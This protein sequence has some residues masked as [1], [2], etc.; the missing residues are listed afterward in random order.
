MTERRKDV[1]GG[2]VQA[3]SCY[4]R[5]FRLLASPAATR[6]KHLLPL[7]PGVFS[8]CRVR[9]AEVSGTREPRKA[10]CSAQGCCVLSDARRSIPRYATTWRRAV[11]RARPAVRQRRCF[12]YVRQHKYFRRV[13]STASQSGERRPDETATASSPRCGQKTALATVPAAR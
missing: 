3:G 4:F 2:L 8:R 13:L 6:L 10:R 1:A 9:A 11:A 7:D 12:Y 5:I